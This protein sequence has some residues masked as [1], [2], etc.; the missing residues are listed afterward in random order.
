[1]R[2][3]TGEDRDEQRAVETIQA[4]VDAGIAVFDTAHAYGR[5]AGELGHNERLLARAL[6]SRGDATVARIVTKGG[7]SRPEGA[8][9]PDGRAKTI[10]ADC[11]A[12]LEALDGLQIDL[13]LVHAPDP[14]TPWTTT[15]RALARLVDDGLVRRVGVANV[16]RPQLDE[17]LAQAPIA[18]AQVALSPFDDRGVRG[19]VLGRCVEAGIPV[20]AHSPL[21][22]PRRKSAL[23]RHAELGEV[24]LAHDATP[25]EVALAWLLGLA[26][27]LVAIPG[28]R[29]PDAA[30]SARRA[31][32]IELDDGDRDLLT[33]A[34]G[35]RPRPRAPRRGAAAAEVVLVMGIPG[36]GKTRVAGHYLERGFTRLNR[37][38]RGGTLRELA[39]ALDESLSAGVRSVV[40]DNTYLTRASRSHVLE[41]A[42][43]HGTAVECVWVD[44]PLAQAQVNL[45]DRLLERLG[46]LPPP[47]E[48]R[49]LARREPGIL[50][51]TSQMRALRELEPPTEEE[52][53][54]SIRRLPFERAATPGNLRPGL[55]VARSLLRQDDWRDA[56]RR[57]A[58][59]TPVLLFDWSPDGREHDLDGDSALLAVALGV[60]VETALCPHG[61]GPPICWC[62]PPL[63]GLPLAFARAHEVDPSDSVLVGTSRAHRALAEALGARYA[64]A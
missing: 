32:D 2:L 5:G 17:A 54:A 48:L 56:L 10:R 45:V 14:R 63:P 22:G 6:R 33:R 46:R 43:R 16:N 8:W 50:A 28:A 62:R 35:G 47:E 31:A 58:P 27:G 42:A 59:E 12:S 1:M 19:G 23:A 60:P 57:I 64:A 53:F 3:S 21:G 41:V 34:F 44:T 24:A 51:P 30:R 15:V 13:Y 4:A 38:A 49:E 39:D 11:E 18:V 55:F 61:G 25:A 26:P 37:D 9:I 7:M 20:I 29:T 40:L 36:A 52:G